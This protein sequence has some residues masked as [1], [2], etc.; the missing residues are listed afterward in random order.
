M[1]FRGRAPA[2][3]TT[4]SV[5]QIGAGNRLQAT[6]CIK[7]RR[8]LIG[9]GFVVNEAVAVSRADRLVVEARCLRLLTLNASELGANE[10]PTILKIIRAM[11]GPRI[12][13]LAV[14]CDRLD[15]LRSFVGVRRVVLSRMC[16]CAIEIIFNDLEERSR[17]PQKRRCLRGCRQSGGVFAG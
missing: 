11:L 5:L 7:P 16:E 1:D 12:E 8:N 10:R 13:L 3:V 2:E 4:A 9:N 14:S 17:G 6:R 15:P